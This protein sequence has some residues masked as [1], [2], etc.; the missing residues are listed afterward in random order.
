MCVCRQAGVCGRADVSREREGAA[1]GQC[2]CRE[3]KKVEGRWKC[4]G[5]AS[6]IHGMCGAHM[7][8]AKRRAQEVSF[9]HSRGTQEEEL[10]EES[11]GASSSSSSSSRQQK[12]GERAAFTGG[13][14][15]EPHFRRQRRGR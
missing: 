1:S 14:G 6:G 5:R 10:E 11:T 4:R 15:A 13:G 8:G 7:R 3:S 12:E 9:S 2:E